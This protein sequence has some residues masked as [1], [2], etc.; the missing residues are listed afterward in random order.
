MLLTV[1]E[2]FAYSVK[3]YD[4][5]GNR[6]GTYK[7]EGDNYVLYDFNDKKVEFNYRLVNS[8]VFKYKMSLE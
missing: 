7:K 4:Q 2:T 6:V 8:K 1:C 5:W 3:V